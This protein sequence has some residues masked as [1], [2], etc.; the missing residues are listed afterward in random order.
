MED[1]R[2]HPTDSIGLT[3]KKRL[4]EN[5]KPEHLNAVESAE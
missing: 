3:D 4:A 2:F 1:G 5:L